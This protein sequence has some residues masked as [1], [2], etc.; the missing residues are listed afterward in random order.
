MKLLKPAHEVKRDIRSIH[1]TFDQSLAII[2]N[3]M[4]IPGEHLPYARL[5]HTVF[6]LPKDINVIR[7]L[8]HLLALGKEQ[9][10]EIPEKDFCGRKRFALLQSAFDFE[11]GFTA[12]L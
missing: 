9:R 4:N 11:W 7:I 3:I 6:L 12:T 8:A 2:G 10:Y 5:L 1:L